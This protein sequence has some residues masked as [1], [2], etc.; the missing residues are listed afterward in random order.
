MDEDMN[1]KIVV[2]LD[3]GTT[4]NRA[5]AFAKDGT[6][7]AKSY[8]EFS[9]IFPQPGWVEHDPMEIVSTTFRALKEVLAEVGA[10]N[11]AAIG[12]TNQRETTILWDRA[13]GKPVYNAIVW[14]CRRTADICGKLKGKRNFLKKRT[15][16]F[17]D[18]Y[19]SAT[20]IKW[21]LDRVPGV[22]ERAE[23]GEICFGTVDSW[24]LW[25][26][27]GGKVHA[28]EPSNASRTLIFNIKTLKFD[29]ALLK[30]FNI[31]PRVLPEVRDSDALF[32]ATDPKITGQAIPVTGI[33]GDQQAALFAHAGWEKGVVKNT[34]GTGLF[35]MTV[36]KEKI[37]NP[38]RLISTVAWKLRGKTE[39]AVEGSVFMGGAVI[40]WLR[41]NLKIIEKASDSEAIAG[42]LADNQGV[43]F[44]PA[45]QGLGAPYWDP[46]ARGLIIGL[47][48]KISQAGIIRAAVESMAY[49]T[50]DVIEAMRREAGLKFNLLRVDGGA[51][52][53]DFLMQFQ[54]DILGLPVE[55][56]AM[57][58]K[59]ALGAAGVAGISSGVWTVEEFRK[60]MKI[61]C[62][63][64]P[65]M[66]P[67][68]RE[69]CYRKWQ[70]AV[71]RSLKW[72]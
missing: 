60:M 41:D 16:L 49:Q 31:P 4:G 30:I 28:T 63:F 9:Q 66:K 59:T 14:Q 33:L 56:P 61:D 5:I 55:R 10:E 25:H 1:R 6:V 72:A 2:A 3:L 43:Y 68:V 40:Q 34:Y 26:L 12:I 47:S 21:I 48:R 29:S 58:E 70:E 13:S 24:I 54:A 37:P 22:R 20:K 69:S 38:K 53:D 11:V 35:V 39:Y 19:F 7:A 71:K 15:G 65:A 50:R 36:V 27:T 42:G 46:E 64:Q 23:R 45:L 67:S 8:Y 44:V 32:G 18:P 62:V 51:V 17:L 57:P 52:R